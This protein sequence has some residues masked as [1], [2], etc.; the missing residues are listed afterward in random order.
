VVEHRGVEYAR[1]GGVPLLFDAVIPKTPAPPPVVILVHGGG[2]VRGDR[3][4]EVAPLFRPLTDAG[5]AWFSIDYR[6]MNDFTQFGNAIDDVAAAVRF[7]KAHAAEY[8]VDAE[9]IALAGESAGGQLAAMAALNGAEDLRVRA[10][11]GLYAP[12][13]LP[14]LAKDSKMIPQWVRDQVRGTPWEGLMMAR[15]KQL[16]PIE[17]VRRGMPPM[18]LIHGTA[19]TLVPVEQSRAMCARVKAAGGSCELYTVE[20]AGHGSRWWE[21]SPRQAHGYKHEMVGWLTKHLGR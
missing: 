19:D 7:V 6:L 20:G 15:L 16:S 18:L 8:R 11:V 21:S 2:W 10:F 5:F 12:M 1:P 14:A 13:D 3:R 4:V 9:R 17:H